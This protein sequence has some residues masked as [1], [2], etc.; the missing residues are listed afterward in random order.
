MIFFCLIFKKIVNPFWGTSPG[1][2][3]FG[4]SFYTFILAYLKGYSEPLSVVISN[5]LDVIQAWRKNEY[6]G[7]QMYYGVVNSRWHFW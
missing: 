5:L 6:I 2:V 4:L 7:I 1:L 3:H